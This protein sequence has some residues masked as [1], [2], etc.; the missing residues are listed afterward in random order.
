VGFHGVALA[1]LGRL[2]EAEAVAAPVLSSPAGETPDSWPARLAL[3]LVH[4]A[5][6]AFAEAAEQLRRLDEAKRS[7]GLGDPRLCHHASDLIDALIAIGDLA[8]A[9]A[10]ATRLMEEA[11]SSDSPWSLAAATRGL[12]LIEAAHG[13]LDAALAA[14]QR[15]LSLLE[16]LPMPFERA[17]TTFAIGQIHRRRREKR[18]AREALTQ[19]RR[20]FEDHE[21]PIWADRA[22]AELDRIP[23]QRSSADLTPTE[24]TIARLAGQGLTNREIADRTFLSPKTVEV[25]LTRIYRK[26]GVRSRAGLAGRLAGD[27]PRG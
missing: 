21:A 22:R 23:H 3:G 13:R 8:E 15:S 6:G 18:L 25:N 19:A 12:A 1:L 27:A 14:A 26:L 17:R 20:W 5:R 10:V 24:E 7:A 11:V 16:G 9:E 2:D 4:L